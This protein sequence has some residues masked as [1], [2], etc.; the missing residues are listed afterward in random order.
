MTHNL[1]CLQD[2]QEV[3]LSVITANNEK[4][5][6]NCKRTV[7]INIKLKGKTVDV[8]KV[9]HVLKLAANL[10]SVNKIV[11]KGHKVIFDSSGCKIRD[12]CGQIIGDFI[13]K[14]VSR[15]NSQRKSM[16]C[17]KRG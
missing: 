13:R 8:E 17:K 15:R 4:I 1:E 14:R 12:T 6:A 11:E 9:L 10:L 7:K 3:N 2:T 16:R 5:T